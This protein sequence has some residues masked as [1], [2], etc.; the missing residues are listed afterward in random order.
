MLPPWWNED[1][2]D[3]CASSNKGLA[4]NVSEGCMSV[5]LKG[6]RKR[7]WDLNSWLTDQFQNNAIMSDEGTQ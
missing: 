4:E 5:K 2:N 6:Q 3:Y 7:Q 1:V